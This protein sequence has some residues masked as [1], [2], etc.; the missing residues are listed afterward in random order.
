MPDNRRRYANTI[1]ILRCLIIFMIGVSLCGAGLGYIWFLDD[2]HAIGENIKRCEADLQA[3]RNRKE[4]LRTSS[5]TLSSATQ[6][7]A[8]FKK[9]RFKK[10][11]LGRITPDQQGYVTV[12]KVPL[13]TH[14]GSGE[15]RTVVNEGKRK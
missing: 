12:V 14:A 8:D 15:L 13:Q 3:L 11:G 7:E 9:G 10:H 1:P 6:L 5:E 4:G 2:M